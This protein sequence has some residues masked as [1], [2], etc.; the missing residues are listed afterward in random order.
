M[1]NPDPSH[2]A[3]L[4]KIHWLVSVFCV[5]TESLLRPGFCKEISMIAGGT[6]LTPC[7]QDG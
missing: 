3:T 1:T 7:W 2:G 6:G 5:L 4:S